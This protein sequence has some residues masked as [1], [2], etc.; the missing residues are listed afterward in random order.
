M[1]KTELSL[2]DPSI[3]AS[4]SAIGFFFL[5]DL[6]A[7]GL[8]VPVDVE[9]LLGAVEEVDLGTA[10]AVFDGDD[11][12]GAVDVNPAGADVTI[13]VGLEKMF[14]GFGILCLGDWMR[15]PEVLL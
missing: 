13:V 1:R 14:V 10:S 2:S 7:F 8:L 12:I 5:V 15:K 11:D 9:E 4:V 6:V 3:L